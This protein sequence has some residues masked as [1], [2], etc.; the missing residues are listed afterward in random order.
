MFFVTNMTYSVLKV[1][2]NPNQPTRL[3]Q[4]I[5]RQYF[6]TMA[7]LLVSDAKDLSEILSDFRPISGYISQT[8]QN[9]D[10]VTMER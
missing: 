9:R 1:P 8:M 4:R 7:I 2:L 10:I 5:D 6:Y 3:I